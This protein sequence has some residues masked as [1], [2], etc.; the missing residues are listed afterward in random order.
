MVGLLC[1]SQ[2]LAFLILHKPMLSIQSH[3]L[4]GAFQQLEKCLWNE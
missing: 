4:K 3:M 2:P 1:D